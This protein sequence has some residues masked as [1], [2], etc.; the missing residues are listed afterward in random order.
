MLSNFF[1]KKNLKALYDIK[2]YYKQKTIKMS[3]KITNTINSLILNEK[4][5]QIESIKAFLTENMD[6]S[7]EVCKLLDDFGNLTE[8][9]TIKVKTTKS[10]TNK[11]GTPRKTRKLSFYNHWLGQR[12]TSLSNEQQNVPNE[13]K[14]VKTQRMSIISKEWSSYKESPQFEKEKLLWENEYSE[15]LKNVEEKKVEDNVEEKKVEDN[16][17]EKKVEKKTVEK[18]KVEKKKVEK[19]KVEKKKVE[20]KKVDEKKKVEQQYSDSDDSDDDNH[21]LSILPIDSEDE[22]SSDEE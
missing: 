7:E 14:I 20:E 10:K 16:V 6:N 5:E 15:K 17:E 19:K 21:Q 13:Q 2:N 1:S 9:K 12:M 11:D 22:S 4:I 18:K 3:N 8:K